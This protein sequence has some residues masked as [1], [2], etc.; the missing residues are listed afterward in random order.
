VRNSVAV[1]GLTEISDTTI[2]KSTRPLPDSQPLL[3][4]STSFGQ[5]PPPP[6]SNIPP[7]TD[8][9]E[10][11]SS[12]LLPHG[13]AAHSPSSTITPST[14]SFPARPA[15]LQ[16]HGPAFPPPTTV[17]P[18]TGHL[19]DH[20]AQ[21]FSSPCNS[22]TQ[23]VCHSSS[24]YTVALHPVLPEQSSSSGTSTLQPMVDESS[25]P[26]SLSV[27]GES[28]MLQQEQPPV[29]SASLVGMPSCQPKRSASGRS[30]VVP[31]QDSNHSGSSWSNKDYV[32]PQSVES[33]GTYV[34]Q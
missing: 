9:Y 22:I 17:T 4:T 16:P 3:C 5:I 1:T 21:A 14:G 10:S 23:P 6:P 33:S 12:T 34:D 31:R 26:S 24:N 2:P 15:T 11:T 25:P 8:A 30:H 13:Q 7:P 19:L 28:M 29:S 32:S 18:P 27:S 20:L